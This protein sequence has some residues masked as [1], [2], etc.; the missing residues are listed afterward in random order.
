M[1]SEIP[2]KNLEI[3]YINDKITKLNYYYA[4]FLSKLAYQHKD[5]VQLTSA[6]MSYKLSEGHTCIKLSDIYNNEIFK[7]EKGNPLTDFQFPEIDD[8]IR[9]LKETDLLG[10]DND[11]NNKPFILY[12]KDRLYF[13]KFY[14]Y[15]KEL[16]GKILNMSKVNNKQLDDSVLKAIHLLTVDNKTK[17]RVDYQLLGILT[18]LLK[19][20]CIISGGAGTGKTYTASM[21][22]T[23]LLVDN[24]SLKIAIAAPT[25]KAANRLLES[26]RQNYMDKNNNSGFKDK[27]GD[28]LKTE[29]PDTSFTIHRL[30][31]ASELKPGYYYKEDRPLAYDVLIVDE[32]SMVDLALMVHLFRASKEGSKIIL[33]GD[34]NQ[35]VAVETG[36]VLS[37]ICG[38]GNMNKF[39]P[40]GTDLLKQY[41]FKIQKDKYAEMDLTEL[42]DANACKLQDCMVELIENKR[43]DEDSDIDKL[44]K[45]VNMGN[46]NE[47]LKIINNEKST[48]MEFIM[49]ESKNKRY[50]DMLKGFIDKFYVPLLEGDISKE[51][52]FETLSK[53]RILTPYRTGDFRVELINNFIVSYLK[54][55][56][57]IKLNETWYSGRPIIIHKN[58]Y[59]VQLFNG[60][61]GIFIREQ[62]RGSVF[63]DMGSKGLSP[64]IL[65][66]HETAY[67][68]TVHKAQG[69]EFEEVLLILGDRESKLLN[70]QLLYTA[71]TRAKKKLYIYGQ[72][73]LIEHA[74]LN[75]IERYSALGDYLKV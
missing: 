64:N 11:N 48:N 21:I 12:K 46:T 40:E 2:D 9:K 37:E 45:F 35:L 63:F 75:P 68:M 70:R 3:L 56:G 16:A 1:F 26:V 25:G 22:I 58:D 65:P 7:D 6:L 66:I 39:T 23:I 52:A 15:E 38:I 42:K 5:L 13:Q 41:L 67:A 20:I 60:D 71:V 59:S 50:F 53:F 10:C 14:N 69:S 29:V 43:Q 61:I 28:Y 33:L 49:F 8:W 31:G 44:A 4:L 72:T 24:P 54:E 34:K 51:S 55:K 27:L 32:S 30:L 62:D 36:S 17:G 19:N 47:A 18:S 73:N 74:I 57:L